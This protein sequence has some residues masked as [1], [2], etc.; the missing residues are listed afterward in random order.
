MKAEQNIK[1]V[2]G[3]DCINDS[4]KSRG[5][6]VI[7]KHSGNG[8]EVVKTYNW[9]HKWNWFNKLK[10]KWQIWK[11]CLRYRE[12]QIYCETNKNFTHSN[13]GLKSLFNLIFK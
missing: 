11:M 13:I 5:A 3:I 6:I 4:G 1:Y 8:I 7:I 9:F 2:A 12:V 10:F